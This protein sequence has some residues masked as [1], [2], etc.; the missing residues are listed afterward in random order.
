MYYLRTKAASSAVKFTVTHEA[1]AQPT[2][3]VEVL[4]KAEK[5]ETAPQLEAAAANYQTAHATTTLSEPTEEYVEGAACVID[6]DGNCV[7]CSA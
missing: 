7:M 6:D 3:S 5:L 2:S 4:T 1:Q